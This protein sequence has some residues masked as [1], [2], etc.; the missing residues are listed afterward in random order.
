MGKWERYYF[1]GLTA[2]ERA[3]KVMEDVSRED[4]FVKECTRLAIKTVS[5][6][7][8]DFDEEDIDFEF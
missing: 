2:E 1:M 8:K 5:Q 7:T 4:D 6:F 3:E